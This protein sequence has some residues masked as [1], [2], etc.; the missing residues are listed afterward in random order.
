MRN[1]FYELTDRLGSV[2]NAES[3]EQM[4][5]GRLTARGR[6]V[7]GGHPGEHLFL[8][9]VMVMT[10]TTNRAPHRIGA[11]LWNCSGYAGIRSMLLS[12][13]RASIFSSPPI[14]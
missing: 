2:H 7:P 4:G 6:D 5:M 9:L 11:G 1:D 8:L 3:G 10:L 14:A 12:P 13:I